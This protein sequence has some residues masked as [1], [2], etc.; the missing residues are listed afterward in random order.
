VSSTGVK[1]EYSAPVLATVGPAP[2]GD[3]DPEG[4]KE[5]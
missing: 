2:G 3:T 1:S 4:I 5:H